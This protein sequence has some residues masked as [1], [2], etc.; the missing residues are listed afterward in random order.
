[1][2]KN[3]ISIALEQLQQVI[4]D[5]KDRNTVVPLHLI[6]ARI[7]LNRAIEKLENKEDA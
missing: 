2:I 7:A 1:M 4:S 5:Y 3:D 6:R